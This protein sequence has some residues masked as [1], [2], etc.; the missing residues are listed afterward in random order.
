MEGDAAHQVMMVDLIQNLSKAVEILNETVSQ[1][2]Q[3]DNNLAMKI[4]LSLKKLND[5]LRTQEQSAKED[6]QE[7]EVKIN[8]LNGSSWEIQDKLS[9][10]NRTLRNEVMKANLKLESKLNQT[11]G[12]L[13][14]N[15][16]EVNTLKQ[17]ITDMMTA[18]NNT[19]KTYVKKDQLQ[20]VHIGNQSDDFSSK[21]NKTNI[22]CSQGFGC[23]LLPHDGTRCFKAV[24]SPKVNWETAQEECNKLGGFLVEM[25]DLVTINY[26][27]KIFQPLYKDGTNFWLGGKK[28]NEGT[29]RWATSGQKLSVTDWAADEPDNDNCMY[30]GFSGI[31]EKWCDNPCSRNKGYICQRNGMTCGDW[32]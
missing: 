11:S 30:F 21:L 26:V 8:K 18:L 29:W 25:P 27:G 3:R 22:F 19:L 9:S 20:N 1:R 10:L 13:E 16:Q 31:G 7:M 17:T 12:L 32:V 15:I 28:D 4:D 5:T 2:W 14:E 23:E 24:T 6:K